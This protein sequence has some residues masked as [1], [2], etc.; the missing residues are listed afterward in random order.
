MAVDVLIFRALALLGLAILVAIAARRLKLPYTV[1]LVLAGAGLAA[2]R[3]DA[4]L[5]LTHD[6]IFDVVLPPLL[7]EAALNLGWR[8]F[9]RELVPVLALSTVGVL[10]CAGV[11]A[12][13]L[14]YWIGWPIG[15]ALVFGALISA[16]DPI[17]VIALLKEAGASGRL[18]LVIES[19]SLINDGTAAVLFTTILAWAA[20][21]SSQSG[22][23][24]IAGAFLGVAGGGLFVGLA[25]GFLATLVAGRTDDHLV[26]TALSAVAAFGSFLIAEH[27]HVSGVLAT[28]AAGIVMGNLGVLGPVE[29]PSFWM[30]Q[31]GRS[32]VLEF[33]EFA[34][35]LANS[36]VF[37]L[38]GSAL[39]EVDFSREGWRTLA[40]GVLLT[41]LGRAIAVYPIGA[42]LWPTR[43]AIP[44]KE[45][46]FLWWGGLRGALAL[47]LALALPYDLPRRED[48][49]IV[50]FAVVAFSIVIQGLTAPF[51]LKA[52]GL[53][54]KKAEARA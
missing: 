8:E 1:G 19:E 14:V 30:T 20:H 34:A 49:L 25:I 46:H 6:L 33:W 43:W 13:G 47:A 37:L 36:L 12:G 44:L 39:A 29:R 23:L 35:F 16:T 10:L 27:F 48:I 15:S 31:R 26:E 38:I 52:L 17:A 9:R 45:Q 54:G 51:V 42:A 41:L 4:G 21:D 7:F 24:A 5:A 2:A 28:V 40:I 32:F 53:Q 3:V 11:V 18:R 50:A 22:P